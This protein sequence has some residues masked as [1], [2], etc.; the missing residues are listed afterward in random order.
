MR[1]AGDIVGWNVEDLTPLFTWQTITS[2]VLSVVA[3]LALVAALF[4]ERLR[5]WVAQAKLDMS[6]RVA[7]P[8]THQVD[9]TTADGV[10]VATAIYAR[11]R[12]THKSG[13]SARDAEIM[14]TRLWRFDAEDAKTEVESFIPLPLVWSHTKPPSTTARVPRG[15]LRHCDLAEFTRGDDETL[16]QLT[17]AVRPNPVGGSEHPPTRLV[18]GKYEFE[19][20]LAG[21]NVKPA[22]RRWAVEFSPEWSEDETTMLSRIVFEA[23]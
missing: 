1:G 20:V 7:P 14:V 2:L 22:R 8:D 6:I 4:Q 23:L 10:K 11:I 19:V 17:T 16:L 5:Q 13:A 9:L 21:E 12:V 3:V 15:L 18:P